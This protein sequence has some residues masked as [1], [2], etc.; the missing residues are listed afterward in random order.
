VDLLE[1]LLPTLDRVGGS[2]AQRDVME[3]TLL[4]G[5]VNAGSTRRAAALLSARLDRRPS[6]LDGHRLV[7]LRVRAG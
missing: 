4:L 6:P 3:E 7:T 2:A 1:D 5:L